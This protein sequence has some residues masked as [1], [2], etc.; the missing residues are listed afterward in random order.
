MNTKYFKE[1][2]MLQRIFR[3]LI[4]S[5]VVSLTL[6]SPS[7]VHSQEKYKGLFEFEKAS[8]GKDAYKTEANKENQMIE[9][10]NAIEGGDMIGGIDWENRVIYSVGDGV[11][12]PNAISAA[13]ARVR[14]KRA[15]IDEAYGRMIEMANEVR[16]DA[17]STT[18]NYVNENR[19]V[20]TKVSGMVKN[21]EIVKIN[22]LEDGSYQIMMK[23]PMDGVKGLGSALLPVQMERIR[24]VRVISSTSKEDM[25][26]KTKSFSPKSVLQPTSKKTENYTG[27]I[28]DTKGLGAKPA[29]YPKILVENGDSIYD[30]SSANPNATIEEGL[31]A[32]RMN[33]D[34][35]KQVSRIGSNPLIV[36]AQKVSGKY[37]ADIVISDSDAQKIYQADSKS[38]ILGEAKVVVVID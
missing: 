13:Q 38:G 29:M 14:A 19:I 30:V 18:R 21:A 26:A 10:V 12:P 16:V 27:L 25:M 11:M 28:I 36:K 6:L 24:K 17:E 22:Q 37:K 20:R 23:M 5:M 4:F 9:Q 35:A 3:I 7:I 33:L 34:A 2:E 8:E 1:L 15:A 31:V 32:Y